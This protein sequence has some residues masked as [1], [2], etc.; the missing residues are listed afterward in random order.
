[1]AI[2]SAAQVV[3]TPL[4]DMVPNDMVILLFITLRNPEVFI[5]RH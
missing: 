1:M 4:E 3:I 5:C 2:R